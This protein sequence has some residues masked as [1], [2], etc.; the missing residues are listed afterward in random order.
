MSETRQEI[1]EFPWTSP[2]YSANTRFGHWAKE[3]QAKRMVKDV[4]FLHAASRR[5]PRGC[6]FVE[7]TLVY[8]PIRGGKRDPMNLTPLS[9]A[10]IDGLVEYGLVPDDDPRYLHEHTPIIAAPVGSSGHSANR[11]KLILDMTLR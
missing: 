8:V 1:L 2:P 6:L 10:L 7:V 9:K 5:L 3:A 4:A 11:I